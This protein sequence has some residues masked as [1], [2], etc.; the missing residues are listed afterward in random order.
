MGLEWGGVCGVCVCGGGTQIMHG[1][2]PL[3][4]YN[5][6]KE[7]G[8]VRMG[9]VGAEL[10]SFG[11]GLVWEGHFGF[12]GFGGVSNNARTARGGGYS[13]HA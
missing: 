7:R 8:G 6:G 2:V 4:R 12:V 10:A 1:R 13:Y 9:F 3:H 11:E 5:A